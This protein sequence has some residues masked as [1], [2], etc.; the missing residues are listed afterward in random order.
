MIE[1]PKWNID[2]ASAH[3]AKLSENLQ[4]FKLAGDARRSTMDPSLKEVCGM[5]DLIALRTAS[6]GLMGV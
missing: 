2:E 4:G 1:S 3:P 5:T 6:K